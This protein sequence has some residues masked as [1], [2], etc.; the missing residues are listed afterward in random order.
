MSITSEDLDN[1][2]KIAGFSNKISSNKKQDLLK[3]LNYIENDLFAKIEGLNLDDE[4][5]NDWIDSKNDRNVSGNDLRKYAV[6][7]QS[8][9]LFI[10][11]LTSRP[12][13]MVVRD[14]EITELDNR[15]NLRDYSDNMKDGLYVVKKFNG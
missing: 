14:D 12:Y 7:S 13:E 8:M 6:N 3:K 15:D 10:S 9:S 1:L 2:F 11:E 4:D 5:E